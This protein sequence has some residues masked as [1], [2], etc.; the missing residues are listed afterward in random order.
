MK[1]LI[2]TGTLI[3]NALL[4][5]IREKKWK[6]CFDYYATASGS[7]H[8]L[9]I[10]DFSVRN[11]LFPPMS[12]DAE[13]D[14]HEIGKLQENDGAVLAMYVRFE[15]KMCIEPTAGMPSTLVSRIVNI[16]NIEMVTSIQRKGI[17]TG[18]LSVL[19]AATELGGV[20][21]TSICNPNLGLWLEKRH[22]WKK[23]HHHE[24]DSMIHLNGL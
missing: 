12:L 23:M 19:E 15:P 3:G 22:G 6:G 11:N 8:R 9:G 17:L 10:Q 20:S 7:L 18:M 2:H 24:T 16:T 21:I 14:N 13:E 5:D 1:S 4:E